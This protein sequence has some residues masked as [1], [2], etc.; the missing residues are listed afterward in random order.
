MTR[1]R[2]IGWLVLLPLCAIVLIFALA[3]R[4][5]VA[6]N[7]NPLTTVDATI[8]G[9]GIPLFLVIYICLFVGIALGGLAVWYSQGANRREMRHYR[10][11]VEALR[12]ELVATRR[13][14]AAPTDAALLAADDL[15]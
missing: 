4:H 9:Y 7:F 8:P 3:N 12:A 11:E 10:K 5:L 2:L 6:V 15:I 1:K 13:A 14:P